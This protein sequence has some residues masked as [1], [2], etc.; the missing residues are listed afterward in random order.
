MSQESQLHGDSDTQER[1]RKK[2]VKPIKKVLHAAREQEAAD[3]AIRGKIDLARV[4]PEEDCY[5]LGKEFWIFTVQQLEFVLSDPEDGTTNE[6]SQRILWREELL[7]KLTKSKSH[8]VDRDG[9]MFVAEPNKATGHTDQ[10]K[11]E[12][13]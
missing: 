2:P 13:V 6:S 8:S 1:K 3:K 9:S 12:R 5:F 11:P 4:L 7:N 10:T